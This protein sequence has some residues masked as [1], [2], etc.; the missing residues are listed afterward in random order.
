MTEALMGENCLTAQEAWTLYARWLQDS[1]VRFRSD[2]TLV[3]EMLPL[4]MLQVGKK[5]SPK[6]LGDYYLVAMAT[7]LGATLVTMDTAIARLPGV[8]S[9]RVLTL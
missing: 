2:S 6:A 9:S 4:L 7:A 8:E 5:P 1:S 3:D